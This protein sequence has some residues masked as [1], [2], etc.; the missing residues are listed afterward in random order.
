MLVPN[1]NSSTNTQ[2]H[3]YQGSEKD[4][5]IKGNGNDYATHHRHLDPRVG[6]WMSRDPKVTASESPYVSMN[7]NPML[8]NDIKG[9][10]IK[11]SHNRIDIKYENGNLY[12]PNGSPF[13]GNVNGYLGKVKQSLDNINSVTPGQVLLRE[14]ESSKFIFTIKNTNFSHSGN[15]FVADNPAYSRLALA[16]PSMANAAGSGGTIYWNPNLTTSGP[17][18]RGNNER[19]AFIGLTHEFGHALMS[20]RG[21]DNAIKFSPNNPTIEFRTITNDDFNAMHIENQVRSSFGLPLR[22]FYTSDPNGNGFM[23]ALNGNTSTNGYN[24]SI[25]NPIEINYNGTFSGR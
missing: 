16:V 19:P 7:N 12:N 24:Y 11:I 14:I 5:E 13:A 10:T 2:R 25:N 8:F 18:Q 22:E 3:G 20:K 6:R 17:N 23:R 1:R 9:D 15:E 4:D 21:M